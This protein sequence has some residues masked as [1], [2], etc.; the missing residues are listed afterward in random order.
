MWRFHLDSP[1]QAE[2][3]PLLERGNH[4]TTPNLCPFFA[5]HQ[6]RALAAEVSPTIH[7]ATQGR[8]AYAALVTEIFTA[9]RGAL[10]RPAAPPPPPT[11]TDDSRGYAGPLHRRIIVT[12]RAQVNRP[13]PNCRRWGHQNRN[14]H[15]Q[16]DRNPSDLSA[17]EAENYGLGH[18]PNLR[19]HYPDPTT[20]NLTPSHPRGTGSDSM[21]RASNQPAAGADQP[22]HPQRVRACCPQQP[23]RTMYPPKIVPR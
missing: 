5:I 8:A 1:Q 9:L 15:R 16:A 10:V 23:R 12:T 6:I 21:S 22:P 7:N 4:S 17:N 2:A 20:D 11:S 3:I 18:L 13:W 19:I 14:T